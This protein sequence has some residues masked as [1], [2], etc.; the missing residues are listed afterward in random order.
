M[1]QTHKDKLEG[2]YKNKMKNV[3]GHNCMNHGYANW[4][5]VPHTDPS[6]R[7]EQQGVNHQARQD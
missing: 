1:Q 3:K 7:G 4:H 5:M 6:A 2:D